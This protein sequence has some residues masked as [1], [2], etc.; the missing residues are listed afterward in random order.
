[1]LFIITGKRALTQPATNSASNSPQ[2]RPE[3]QGNTLAGFRRRRRKPSLTPA[4]RPASKHGI[5]AGVMGILH[6]A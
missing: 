5:G 3:Q 4:P 1:M 2:R 6:C